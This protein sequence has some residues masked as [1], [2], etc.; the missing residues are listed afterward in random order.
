LVLIISVGPSSQFAVTAERE[1]VPGDPLRIARPPS[2][3]VPALEFVP[4]PSERKDLLMGLS[5]SRGLQRLA[6]FLILVGSLGLSGCGKGTA[7]VSGKVSYTGKLLKGG[8]VTFVS[9]DGGPT[10]TSSIKEDGTY[11]LTDVPVGTVKVCVETQSLNPVGK[12]KTM[13]YSPPPGMQ[14]PEGFGGGGSADSSKRYMFIP[15]RFSD[16]EKTDVT[17]EVKPGTQE[18]N[19]DL[20]R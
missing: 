11:T 3:A 17:Y 9:T 2:S 12:P 16:P 14:A 18:Y 19:I 7:T 10:R 6:L 1:I 13:K 4:S 20:P 15:E 8:N 5:P